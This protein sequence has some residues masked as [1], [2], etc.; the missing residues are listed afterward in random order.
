MRG[1][2]KSSIHP[3]QSLLPATR[4]AS[5]NGAGVDLTNFDAACVVID[6]G[7]WTNGTHTFEVQDSDDNST[8]TAVP[9]ANLDGTAPVIDG[10]T[11]DEQIYEIGYHGT[12]RYL[13]VAVTVTGSPATG[14]AYSATV[15]RG[16]GR[17]RP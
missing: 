8:F 3:T 17:V 4:T 12:K 7:A 9:A 14:A 5:A 1:D 15:I 2:I 6:A 10:A 16:H 11:D 13:R